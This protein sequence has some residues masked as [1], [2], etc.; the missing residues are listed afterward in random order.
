M[1][2]IEGISPGTY[3]LSATSQGGGR[4]ADTLAVSAKTD[5]VA[6]V[7]PSCPRRLAGFRTATTRPITVT[8]GES[9]TVSIDRARSARCMGGVDEVRLAR[10]GDPAD[11]TALEAAI[12]DARTLDPAAYTP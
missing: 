1:Q 5:A 7:G 2:K 10:V 6:R 11:T 4:A 3:A 8:A 9:L 12:A